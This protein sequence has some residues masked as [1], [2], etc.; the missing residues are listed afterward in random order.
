MK[1]IIYH[2]SE[3]IVK[4]EFGKGKPFN[5]YGLGFYC[6]ESLELAKE[7]ACA[8]GKD[9]FANCYELKLN[10]LKILKLNDHNYNI[11]NWLAILMDNRRFSANGNIAKAAKQYLLDNYLPDYKDYDMIIGYRADDSYFSFAG[12]FI[13]NSLSLKDLKSAMALGT[14]GEQVVLKS[15]Q[16]FENIVTLNYVDARSSEYFDK[17]K[18]RDSQARAR[19]QDI[20]AHPFSSDDLYILDIIREGI[21]NGDPRLQ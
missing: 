15:K 21:K 2:G 17:F 19:Y 16:A 7:W 18:L 8:H 1:M 4:P 5:D 3:Y 10:G 12:D 11:L 9:G 13:S 20:S 14:L 6:T